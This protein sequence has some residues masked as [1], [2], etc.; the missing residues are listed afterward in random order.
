MINYGILAKKKKKKNSYNMA[1]Y[2]LLGRVYTGSEASSRQKV[3]TT[4]HRRTGRVMGGDRKVVR[5]RE[6]KVHC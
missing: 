4:K 3:N 5:T 6:Q 1:A 2:T